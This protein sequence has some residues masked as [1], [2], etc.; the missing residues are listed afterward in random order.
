MAGIAILAVA[1]M[2]IVFI[3]AFESMILPRRVRHSYR[4]AR[5]Y[6]RSAWFLWR[7]L[8]LWFPSGRW[9]QSCLS[10]FGPLSLLGLFVIWAMILIFGFALLHWS[11]ETAISF[12]HPSENR[13]AAYWYFS[14]T[15]FFTLGL[16]DLVPTETFGACLAWQKQALVSAFWR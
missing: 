13:F 7:S 12:A 11:L 8:A 3:D 5:T 14:G 6:Y 2:M 9:R 16:G 4:L 1:L 10:I 15:T